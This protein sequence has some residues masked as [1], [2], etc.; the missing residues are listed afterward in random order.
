MSL[1]DDDTYQKAI[2]LK[3]TESIRRASTKNI[4]I[5]V[6]VAAATY[7][8]LTLIAKQF[9]GSQGSDA[10]FFLT[11][12]SILASGIIGS[13]LGT[14]FLPTFINLL[15][16]G[17]KSVAD[18]FASSIF[19]WCFLIVSAVALPIGVW[20]EKFFLSISRFD[21]SQISQM[22]PVL[23]YFS[24]ILL[25]SLITEFFR[26]MA[27]S[28]GKFSIAALTGIFPPLF[29][30]IFLLFFQKKLLEEAL[31]ASLLGA[32]ITALIILVA[33]VWKKGIRITLSFRKDPHTFRFV[34]TSGPYWFA[35]VVTNSATFFCDYMASGLGLGVVTSLAYAQRI[36]LLPL[37][38]FLHP[39]VEISRTKF[40]Q[41]QS[42][43]DSTSLN[44]YYNNLMRFSL[45][46]SVPLSA[47]Y[48]VFSEEIISA[49]F[50]GGAF[51]A[52]NVLIAA[53]CLNMYAWTIP[54][55]SVF[56]I[57]GRACESYQRLLWPSIFGSIGNILAIIATYVL[58]SKLGFIGIPLAKLVVDLI[59]FLPFGFIAFN[60][61][62]G[63]PQY[64][65]IS[66]SFGASLFSALVA[67]SIFLFMNVGHEYTG[68]AP[69][70]NTVIIKILYF[71]SVYFL[72]LL[73]IS[74]KVR[75]L[76]KEIWR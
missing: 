29:L 27:L 1:N 67:A 5:S 58:V 44:S 7:Y 12:L 75:I 25:F 35:N 22:Q 45:Y 39:L 70:L 40:A 64:F 38:V 15:E 49:M 6:C 28:L 42:H 26:I 48:I 65:K 31:V 32:K 21:S 14:V 59:Y 76:A 17:D 66:Q 34:R 62:G 57:N 60:L 43:S 3:T 55:A 11:S 37:T 74:S 41:F 69:A 53:S 36:F 51:Q 9:G 61:F 72:T 2:R 50:Q 18:H 13:L 47:L 24:V 4:L 63:V 56:M 30:I 73:V 8:S 46:F 68:V 52:E 33:V 16:K 71:F 10:Y 19:S 54:L 23:K 20:N